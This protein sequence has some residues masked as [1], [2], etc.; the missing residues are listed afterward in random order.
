M[1]KGKE[2]HD[3]QFNHIFIDKV[4]SIHVYN[5]SIRPWQAKYTD[6]ERHSWNKEGGSRLP[7]SKHNENTPRRKDEL[8]AL[9]GSLWFL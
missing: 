9:L 5:L 3:H 7:L 2:N 6:D 1:L 8:T 4:L